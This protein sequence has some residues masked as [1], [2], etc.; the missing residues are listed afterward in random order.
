MGMVKLCPKTW[1]TF[2]RDYYKWYKTTTKRNP[3]M[4]AT[5]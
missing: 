1:N 3:D 5:T 4:A 2:G